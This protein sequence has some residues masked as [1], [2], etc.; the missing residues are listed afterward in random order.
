MVDIGSLF[1]L[2]RYLVILILIV[3]VDGKE[4]EGGKDIIKDGE[5]D[6]KILCFCVLF[7]GSFKVEKM[8]VIVFLELVFISLF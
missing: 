6:G 8:V 7:Y 4:K 2:F 5:E 1:Y 3:A